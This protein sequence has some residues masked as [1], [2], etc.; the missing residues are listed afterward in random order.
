MFTIFLFVGLTSI[1]S[2]LHDAHF[3]H[4][5]ASSS[6]P[7]NPDSCSAFATSVAA[8]HKLNSHFD[9]TLNILS[10]FAM[11]AVN[12]SNDVYTFRQILYTR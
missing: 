5:A 12:D 4:E 7:I 11:A 3:A 8:F 10:T 6:I 2:A 1:S 9:C